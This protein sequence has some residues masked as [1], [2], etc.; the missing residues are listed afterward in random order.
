[1]QWEGRTHSLRIKTS[2]HWFAE[3]GYEG[4]L[5]YFIVQTASWHRLLGEI[6]FYTALSSTQLRHGIVGATEGQVQSTKKG[7]QRKKWACLVWGM[8]LD[9]DLT[10]TAVLILKHTADTLSMTKGRV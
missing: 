2:G 3:E 10:L 7:T 5:P 6:K 1:M 9:I 8:H 4:N